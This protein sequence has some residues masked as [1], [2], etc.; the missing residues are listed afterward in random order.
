MAVAEH[1]A[2][3]RGTV[4]RATAAD[5]NSHRSMSGEGGAKRWIHETLAAQEMGPSLAALTADP[6]RIDEFYHRELWR[7]REAP[8]CA[9]RGAYW[10]LSARLCGRE[11]AYSHIAMPPETLSCVCVCHSRCVDGDADGH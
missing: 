4:A 3:I 7:I 6:Y 2:G 9:L 5:P 10:H 1:S 8:V 11:Y